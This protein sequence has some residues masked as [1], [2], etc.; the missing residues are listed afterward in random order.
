MERK[1][2][3]LA[4]HIDHNKVPWRRKIIS[5][6]IESC[7][8]SHTGISFSH[9]PREANSVADGLA[10]AGVLRTSNFKAYFDICPGR[11]HQDSTALG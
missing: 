10:K 9:I 8:R 4:L 3:N 6:A 5:N 2:A 1:K 11:T 7:L